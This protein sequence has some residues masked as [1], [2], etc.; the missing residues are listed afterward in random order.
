MIATVL[1]SRL[2]T[3][4][5]KSKSTI[6][7]RTKMQSSLRLAMLASAALFALGGGAQAQQ[8]TPS[9]NMSFF[10]TSV[11]PG[12]GGDLGGLAGA[13]A[14]CQM[15]AQSVGAGGKTWHAYLSTNISKQTGLTEKGTVVNGVG[16]TPN[17]H[18]IMTGSQPDGRAFPGNMNMTCSTQM[19]P[20]TS[21]EFGKV[22]VGH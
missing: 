7:G 4:P 9:P 8:A 21:S 16:D 14:H 1:R 2:G 18:D 22:E 5:L 17:Q 13:D 10:V 15:L 6:T 19:G 3:S 11:G 12:K 20:Y